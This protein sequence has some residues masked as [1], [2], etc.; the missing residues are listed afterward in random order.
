VRA[1]AFLGPESTDYLSG[2]RWPAPSGGEPGQWLAPN[3]PAPSVRACTPDQLPWWLDRELWTVELDGRIEDTGRALLADRGRLVAP[4]AAWT[5]EVASELIAVC[6]AR[7]RD[8]AGTTSGLAGYAED[9]VRFAAEAP[10]PA[11]GAAVAAYVAAHVVAGA[12]DM[13]PGYPEAFAAERRR[14]ALWLRDRLQ[15]NV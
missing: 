1:F 11:R 9:V 7:A 6:A 3:D 12:D 4:V 14:Q 10:Y 15:L 2:L 5:S 8:H 13:Q